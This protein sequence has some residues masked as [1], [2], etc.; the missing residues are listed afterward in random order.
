MTVDT[1]Y[2]GVYVQEVN[3]GTVL[4][5]ATAKTAVP[6][7][8]IYDWNYGV[9]RFASFF[10]Y[11]KVRGASLS[12]SNVLDVTIKSYFA[13]GGTAAYF[14]DS[15]EI[16]SEVPKFDEITLVVSC[17]TYSSTQSAFN[18]LCQ[19]G[20]GRF[21]IVD[22]PN[23]EISST[24]DPSKDYAS[25]ANMAVY[26]PYLSADWTPKD[27]FPSVIAAAIYCRNDR[28]R[29][30]WSAPANLTLQG[31][32]R[33]K[34]KVTDDLQGQFNHGLA[35][36][37]IRDFGEGPVVW[38]AR[39][40]EDSDNWRYVPVR[41]L[42]NAAERDIK[43][44][45]QTM[46]F[47]PNSQPTWERVRAAIDN[48]LYSLWQQGALLGASPKEAYFVRIGEGTTMTSDDIAQG[49]MIASVG[50][51]AVRPAEFIVLQFTQ[52]MTST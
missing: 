11:R 13:N 14:V 15:T 21:G 16:A 48:Y 36:N 49:K 37:M 50:M 23:K 43:R 9:K 35:I 18:E 34:Y 5:V 32:L 6:V 27:I 51:A 7:F 40:L 29:G 17:N 28:T 12:M 44:A 30:V 42:F 22:G 47:E 26:Y 20:S 31:D 38:G 39:T 33:P 1:S 3:D 25:N 46:V 8:A 24:Y 45:M 4:S 10:E 52:N 2:P 19:T 41:R